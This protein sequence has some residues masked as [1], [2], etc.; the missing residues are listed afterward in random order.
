MKNLLYILLILFILCNPALAQSLDIKVKDGDSL[1]IK[2]INQ[3]RL[4]GIDC[5]EY[6]QPF[7]DMASAKL[8]ELIELSKLVGNWCLHKPDKYGRSICVLS[9]QNLQNNNKFDPAEELIK[10]GLAEVEYAD[11]L[12]NSL[13]IAYRIA[14][15]EAKQKKLG[16]W[17]QENYIKPA[18]WRRNNTK[19]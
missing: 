10:A 1:E 2:V 14:E 3:C 18:T 8:R 19:K 13:E 11:T 5:P 6:D 16:I 12:P 4:A 15:K 17:S 7:G 9:L